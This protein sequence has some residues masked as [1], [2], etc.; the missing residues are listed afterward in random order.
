MRPLTAQPSRAEQAYQAI[1]DEICEGGLPAGA[2]LVQEKLA[3]QLGVSRQPIQQAMALLKS[4]G[5]VVEAPGR[6]LQVTVLDLEMMQRHYEIR[7]ALDK[8]A[9]RLAAERAAQ[10]VKTASQIR[11]RGSVLIE[12][13]KAAVAAGSVKDMI[14]HDV[15]LH[16]FLYEQ[17]GNPFLR[18]AAEPHWRFLRRVMGDV[19]RRATPPADIWREHEKIFEAVVSGDPELAELRAAEH[20][21]GAAQMLAKSFEQNPG[22][23]PNQGT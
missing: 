2:H 4:D 18:Q 14:R 7:G 22:D 16:G 20:V 11:Q 6:G 15:E 5:L 12:A 13:G 9:A 3:E 8:L 19:L 17:S 23:K 10:S 21:V 1:L